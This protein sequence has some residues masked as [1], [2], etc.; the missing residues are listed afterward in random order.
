MNEVRISDVLK[1]LSHRSRFT[2]KLNRQENAF[3]FEHNPISGWRKKKGREEERR[4]EEDEVGENAYNVKR[5]EPIPLE[6]G[7]YMSD[8][9]PRAPLART[10]GAED[11]LYICICI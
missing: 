2:V 11:L 3:S 10:L 7:R 8:S 6:R 9:L 5:S 4:E 1:K